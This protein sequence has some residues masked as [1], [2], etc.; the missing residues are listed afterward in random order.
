MSDVIKLISPVDGSLYA[1]RP[2]AT[3]AAIDQAV[4]EA[5]VKRREI[6]A[7][8][9]EKYSISKRDLGESLSLFY[10]CPFMEYDE[11]ISIL[12]DLV[13]NITPKY[14]IANL[15]VPL[16]RDGDLIEI[17]INDPHSFQ[18]IQ[19]IKRL[20]PGNEI[21]FYV[22][23]SEDILKFV[24]SVTRDLDS[25]ASKESMTAILGELAI[26]DK[27]RP[28]VTASPTIHEDDSAVVRLANQ[29]IIDAY[30]AGAA[31][32]HI[33]PY[34]GAKQTE[35]RFRVDGNCYEHLKVP[36]AYRRPRSCKT[37]SSSPTSP[38]EARHPG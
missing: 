29:I 10:K 28:E 16:R 31:D 15:W 34:S 19:D 26:Q 6:E 7:L 24:N 36:A 18:K 30:K 27:K 21:R 38:L 8:L 12:P 23:L 25:V 37:G 13:K 4:A 2:V 9:M 3:A 33:E 17:L 5:R 35:I 11:R 14:L 20:F 32:I 1:E 22:G